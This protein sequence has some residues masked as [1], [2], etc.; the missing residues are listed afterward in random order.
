MKFNWSKI[1][2]VMFLLTGFIT[3][4]LI[5]KE[6]GFYELIRLYENFDILLVVGYLIATVII[7]LC[8]TWRWHAI[9]QSMGH[10]ITFKNLFVYKVIGNAINF[11]TLGPRI[12]GEAAQVR[13]LAN[14]KIKP[15]NA[16]STIVVDKMVETTTSGILFIIGLF[17]VSLK[18]AIPQSTGAIMILGGILLT[19]IIGIFYYRMLSSKHFFLHIFTFLRLHKSKNKFLKGIEKGIIEMELRMIKF[20]KRD[21]KVFVLAVAISLLSWLAMFA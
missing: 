2:T 5:V 19:L 16:L 14:H 9:S 18:Y 21:H 6:Y 20:Y 7:Y 12:A 1:A 10:K 15:S 4:Y 8:L 13:L 3:T 17:L 11:F